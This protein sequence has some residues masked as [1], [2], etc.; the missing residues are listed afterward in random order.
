MPSILTCL[1]SRQLCSNPKKDDHW[2]LRDFASQLIAQICAKY[3]E[4]YQTLQPRVAK[5]LLR[6]F[7]DPL[8]PHT[9][10]YGAILGLGALGREVVRV[11]V[12]QNVKQYGVGLQ[13]TLSDRNDLKRMEAE[14]CQGAMVQV[15]GNFLREELKQ[16]LPKGTVIA[17][18]ERKSSV[19]PFQV[20]T[21]PEDLEEVFGIFGDKLLP[22]VTRE[23]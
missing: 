5:T 22:Y 8:K 13:P 7:L 20:P 17:S 14:K 19:E 18:G 12:M 23:V 10:Q 9:T 3:G 1:I 21:T 15:L 2:A 4:A 6:A 16:A 11:L